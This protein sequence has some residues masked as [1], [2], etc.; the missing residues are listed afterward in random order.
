ARIEDVTSF[1]GTASPRFYMTY[2]P[3]PPEENYAQILINTISA[4]AT[5]ELVAE[6]IPGLHHYLPNGEILVKQL[7]QGPPVEAPIEVRVKGDDLDAIRKIGARITTLLKNTEGA[8][9]VRTSFQQDYFGVKVNVNEEVA[10]RLGFSSQG[11]ARMLGGGLKGAPV[12]T[13]WEGDNPVDI[14]LR[15]DKEKR[16]SF[17]DMDN[18]YLTSPITGGRAPLR[19]LATLEPEWQHGRI[20]RRNGVRTLTVR[21]EAQLGRPPND[22]LAEIMPRIAA[23]DLPRGVTILYGGELEDQVAVMGQQM[24]SLL[25]SLVLIFMVLLFQFKWIRKSIIIMAAIPMSWFGAFLGLHLTSNPFS[26]TGFLGVISLSGL[27]VRNGIILVEYADKLLAADPS[28]GIRHVAIDAGK[29]RMRP[30]FL[31]AMAAAM[32]VVPMIISGSPLWAPLG[33]VLAVGLVFG[34][35]LTLLI[36]PPLYWLVMRPGKGARQ[37]VP[38]EKTAEPAVV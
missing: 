17:S 2:A 23:M 14:L 11:I 37:P 30:V 5:N 21:S 10:N 36:M 19:Q 13:L 24:A 27:V 8:N 16:D 22:I 18:I 29:R 20:R 25:T 3:Q 34:M 9:F 31:T 28:R 7:Q 12:S 15:L 38:P 1:I 33:S 32:G 6:L 4:R 26:F 35:I